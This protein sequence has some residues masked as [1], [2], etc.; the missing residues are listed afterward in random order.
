[1]R[2]LGALFLA[3]AAIIASAS[4]CKDRTT[5]RRDPTPLASASSSAPKPKSPRAIDG[6]PTPLDPTGPGCELAGKWEYGQPGALR[7]RAS[8][9]PFATLG[10][11]K[12]ASA[13]LLEDAS[14]VAFVELS[15]DKVKAFGFIADPIR[16]HAG[17]PFLFAGYLVAGR[18]ATFL[19]KGTKAGKVDVELE[20]GT[21]VKPIV[22]AREARDC[23]E[24]SLSE[25]MYSARD[26][27]AEHTEKSVVL[28]DHR[29]IPIRKDVTGP[30]VAEIDTSACSS[31]LADVIDH[32][33]VDSRVVIHP[34]TMSP[35]LDYDIVGWLPTAELL[36]AGGG[37][38]GSWATG[39][40]HG[41]LDNYRKRKLVSCNHE[42]ALVAEQLGERHLVAVLAPKVSMRLLDRQ[43]EGWIEV[44]PRMDFTAAPGVKLL[45]KEDGLADCAVD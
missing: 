45:T 6:Y 22:P 41:W 32:I 37:S 24:L 26:G 35:T 39:G 4:A 19:W 43:D 13:T 3:S 31:I 27:I 8:A 25:A 11:A 1:M 30:P 33:G 7:F 38:G 21:F 12:T 18:Q 23:D 36:P 16:L 15:S 42:V 5:V 9:P 29:H 17:K 40:G 28:V 44:F 14:P 2:P 34:C 20:L 10:G